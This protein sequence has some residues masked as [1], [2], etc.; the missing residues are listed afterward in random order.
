MKSAARIG[1]S[2]RASQQILED[3]D[4][5]WGHQVAIMFQVVCALALE[6]PEGLLEL[7]R[8]NQVSPNVVLTCEPWGY[9]DHCNEGCECLSS[10]RTGPYVHDLSLA[11]CDVLPVS[12]EPPDVVSPALI[13]V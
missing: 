3:V 6:V 13:G 12:R 8:L 9:I 7:R 2:R 11:S 1:R 4:I 10:D 5:L